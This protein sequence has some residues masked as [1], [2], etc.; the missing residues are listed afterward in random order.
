MFTAS[1]TAGAVVPSVP[2]PV[3]A[4]SHSHI[5]HQATPPSSSLTSTAHLN[6]CETGPEASTG[7]SPLITRAVVANDTDVSNGFVK[8]GKTLP[9]VF[10]ANDAGES[11][12]KASSKKSFNKTNFGHFKSR[13]PETIIQNSPD[14]RHLQPEICLCDHHEATPG[15]SHRSETLLM[16]GVRKTIHTEGKPQGES[17]SFL[18]P[19]GTQE[20]VLVL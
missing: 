5:H 3:P 17:I 8:D 12:S 16:Q 9:Y 14:L 20:V 7:S 18:V 19:S 2:V 1:M 13:L 6:P 15:D 10:E 4:A 11:A